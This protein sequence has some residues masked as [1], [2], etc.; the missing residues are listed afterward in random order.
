MKPS[1]IINNKELY[2]SYKLSIATA[3]SIYFDKYIKKLQIIGRKSNRVEEQKLKYVDCYYTILMDYLAPT[4]EEDNNLMNL[5][6]IK[7]VER[8]FNKLTESVYTYFQNPKL[9]K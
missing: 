5:E 4:T 7:E 2:D 9:I 1:E 3:Y 8:R 6:Q